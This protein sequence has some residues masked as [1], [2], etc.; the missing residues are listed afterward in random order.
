M[1]RELRFPVPVPAYLFAPLTEGE[2]PAYAPCV[3]YYVLE[4]DDA[5]FL[6]RHPTNGRVLTFD[7]YRFMGAAL[8]HEWLRGLSD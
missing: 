3:E 8:A 5:R 6:V 1:M 7:A 2:I 4:F